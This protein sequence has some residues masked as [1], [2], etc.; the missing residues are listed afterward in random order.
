MKIPKRSEWSIEEDIMAVSLASR[1]VPHAD[2]S[3]HLE[4]QGF[5]RRR[6]AIVQ[7]LKKIRTDFPALMT[8]SGDWNRHAVD[9][10][11]RLRLEET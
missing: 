10:W 6:V 9:D 7:R 4:H 3:R 5:C 1:K 2:I 8:V 11:I